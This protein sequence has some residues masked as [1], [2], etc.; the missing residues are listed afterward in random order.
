MASS[1][2]QD[3]SS[4]EET[5]VQLAATGTFSPGD[6]TSSPTHL[7]HAAGSAPVAGSMEDTEMADSN[8]EEEQENQQ[9]GPQ[10]EGLQVAPT[11][12]DEMD[13][14][15]GKASGDVAGNDAE[16][17]PAATAAQESEAGPA[18]ETD[19]TLE[20]QVAKMKLRKDRK[21]DKAAAEQKRQQQEREA[22]I[23]A[24]LKSGQAKGA[25]RYF[26]SLS[27]STPAKKSKTAATPTATEDTTT[28]STGAMEVDRPEAT[29]GL[30]GV[31]VP[32]AS[33]SQQV[34]GPAAMTYT[35]ALAIGLDVVGDAPPVP[36][37]TPAINY[38][39]IED[40]GPRWCYT[41]VSEGK[42]LSNFDLSNQ[43]HINAG[44]RIIVEGGRYG[45]PSIKLQ[46]LIN[47]EQN[48]KPV[49][50]ANRNQHH[51]IT[52]DTQPGLE[53]PYV[54]G[55]STGRYAME[56]FLM[57]QY[58]GLDP[59]KESSK[60]VTETD[61]PEG[62]T[63]IESSKVPRDIVC[64]SLRV[65][66]GTV[67]YAQGSSDQY[68]KN[69][70][71]DIIKAVEDISKLGGA[72]IKMVFRCPNGFDQGWN[73]CLYFFQRAYDFR[74]PPLEP[75]YDPNDDS[76]DICSLDMPTIDDFQN[77]MWRKHDKN[78]QF[79]SYGQLPAKISNFSSPAELALHCKISV[80][81]SA[82][83][84]L[85]EVASLTGKR[86][87]HIHLVSTL[88][89]ASRG[90]DK[91]NLTLDQKILR[92]SVYAFVRVSPTK[93]GTKEQ[94]TAPKEDT[95]VDIHFGELVRS[96]FGEKFTFTDETWSGRVIQVSEDQ[97]K[98]TGA[99]F[100][101]FAQKPRNASYRMVYRDYG[102]RAD[103]DLRVAQLSIEYNTGPL[104]RTLRAIDRLF[105]ES[106]SDMESLMTAL[107]YKPY[108]GQNEKR[109]DV[110]AGPSDLCSKLPADRL[111]ERIEYCDMLAEYMISEHGL[112]ED[113]ANILRNIAKGIRPEKMRIISAP[114]GCGKSLLIALI[115]WL[116]SAMGHKITIAATG[117]G[118][119][120]NIASR[121]QQV[122]PRDVRGAGAIRV[123]LSGHEKRMAK[124]ALKD[125]LEGKNINVVLPDPDSF[126]QDPIFLDLL[127][128]AAASDFHEK[129][130]EEG[131]DAIALAMQKIRDDYATMH[132][133]RGTR[134]YDFPV[135]QSLAYHIQDIVNRDRDDFLTADDDDNSDDEGKGKQPAVV[136]PPKV[137]PTSEYA[138]LQQQFRLATNREEEMTSEQVEKM[139]GL[140][141]DIAD[142]AFQEASIVVATC[143]YA[144]SDDVLDHFKG[145][146]LLLEEAGAMGIADAAAL[147]GYHG[148]DL[149]VA[150]GD[151]QQLQPQ[152]F[153]WE[154]N[155]ASKFTETSI[156]TMMRLKDVERFELLEQFR[157][158][159]SIAL[160]LN[161]A[162]YDG[163]LRNAPIAEKDH[164]TAVKSRA[165]SKKW[166]VDTAGGNE[167][168]FVHVP[169]GKALVKPG[170][171][172]LQNPAFAKVSAKIA[173]DCVKEGI[174]AQSIV[175]LVFYRAQAELIRHELDALGE[176][177]LDAVKV[178][179]VG[180]VDS[181]QGR[182]GEAVIIDFTASGVHLLEEDAGNTSIVS[183]HVRKPHRL[184]V[185]AGR[186]RYFVAFVGNGKSLAESRHRGRYVRHLRLLVMRMKERGCFVWNFT[187]N[188]GKDHG[189]DTEIV[190]WAD[191]GSAERIKREEAIRRDYGYFNAIV[192][193]GYTGEIAGMDDAIAKSTENY[194]WFRK[195]GVSSQPIEVNPLAAEHGPEVPE[196]IEEDPEPAIP[197]P[198]VQHPG[199]RPA[200]PAPVAGAWRGASSS[201]GAGRAMTNWARN[202]ANVPRDPQANRGSRGRAV[203]RARGAN[204][205]TSTGGGRDAPGQQPRGGSEGTGQGSTDRRGRGAPASRPWGNFGAHMAPHGGANQQGG[206]S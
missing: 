113:Q 42:W 139:L 121:L 148:K 120:D 13:I 193:A 75:Y 66:L 114:S 151:E 99:N 85:A 81:R 6:N 165:V 107:T 97:L 5:R 143:D 40:F 118:A 63:K 25:K 28:A 103:K 70:S 141:L 130:D 109:T 3:P 68:P 124:A 61:W 96:N 117:N 105:D 126:V 50:P 34:S 125:D 175:I 200:L 123:T 179:Q 197:A 177:D 19:G 16:E 196:V 69:T 190:T 82:Q 9:V 180:T 11:K 159:P 135:E 202:Q 161:E 147:M 7:P 201:R 127:H 195:G 23:I 51:Q 156:M 146:I 157:L 54:N 2:H 53:L 185:A 160:Y 132:R 73:K 15:E 182:E 56:D 145:N 84:E 64:I 102:H 29:K 62:L 198:V 80:I 154:V 116:L 77:G 36:S 37:A 203:L 206:G 163:K 106:N 169:S 142:R 115:A 192:R 205:G 189:E 181:Y 194:L 83:K 45:I 133:V 33:G 137:N 17:T 58:H 187:D 171:T 41:Q 188:A 111:A 76:K 10:S 27:R 94:F 18:G 134:A 178:G 155:E 46:F 22:A 86:L 24:A 95:K 150:I 59:T 93:D 48:G 131:R 55:K 166:G 144:T 35:Q 57:I 72:R 71:N 21:A 108:R 149:V 204:R 162:F 101:V 89:R 129:E 140:R 183:G 91:K 12:P 176:S 87:H 136:K 186:G 173:L 98:S 168:F 32:E 44:T 49:L 110:R 170:D 172:S 47:K 184:C 8:A 14:D 138:I 92:E 67:L 158:R 112:N 174:D 4:S 60:W 65:M 153:A 20:A 79:T 164:P 39:D 1:S 199:P 122:K 74:R 26:D 52:F 167:T 30:E 191:D 104:D 88:D 119:V 100:C 43:A 128:K 152:N 38:T 90:G 78:G 31:P